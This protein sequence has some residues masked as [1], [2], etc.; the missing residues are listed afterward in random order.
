MT[1]CKLCFNLWWKEFSRIDTFQHL[2]F[3]T[4]NVNDHQPQGYWYSLYSYNDAFKRITK[5]QRGKIIKLNHAHWYYSTIIYVLALVFHWV[6]YIIV[7][8]Y[9]FLLLSKETLMTEAIQPEIH[10]TC[11]LV[12]QIIY[13][14]IIYHLTLSIL[15]L[16]LY[17]D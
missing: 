8:L 14:T 12:K 17:I 3:I 11:N 6:Y 4:V 9:L 1:F 10:A 13:Y 5:E 16:L 15:L 2:Y 7:P